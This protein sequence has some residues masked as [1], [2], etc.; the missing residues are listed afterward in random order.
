MSTMTST[1]LSAVAF[2]TCCGHFRIARIEREITAE[3]IQPRAALRVGRGADHHR[4][5]HQLADL[6]AHETDA[7]ACAL[8]QQRLA[9]LE[10]SGGDDRV[11]H[12]LQRDRQARRLL[13]GHVV[14]RDPMHA[15]RIGDDVFRETARGRSQHP[16]AWFY[17]G[18][19]TA[20]CLHFPGT[21][22]PEPSAAAARG[23]QQIGAVEARGARPDHHFVCAGLRLWQIPDFGTIVAGNRYFHAVP[24]FVPI[25]LLSQI[26]RSSG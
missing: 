3:F 13:V 25:G 26:R 1:P 22:Q 12:G 15:A 24:P 17:V 23:R 16:V 10:P 2:L 11:V 19:T 9:A 4:R 21:F 8:H 18:H 7:R 14:G 5:A 6:H 20:D